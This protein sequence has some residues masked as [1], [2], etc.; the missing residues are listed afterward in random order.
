MS[1]AVAAAGSTFRV[2][3]S[4]FITIASV[5]WHIGIPNVVVPSLFEAAKKAL[6]FYVD[7]MQPYSDCYDDG[8]FE[9]FQDA[10]DI[11]F[12]SDNQ[13]KEFEEAFD[14]VYLVDDSRREELEANPEDYTRRALRWLN[15]I[16]GV[17][18]KGFG[19]HAPVF[20]IQITEVETGKELLKYDSRFENRLSGNAD[21]DD[22]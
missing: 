16:N 2:F 12:A 7:E 5:E 6:D 18:P 21:D 22:E 14:A 8:T 3:G 11:R 13:R 10:A 20:K 1:S 17:E 15:L 4:R 9:S 19:D